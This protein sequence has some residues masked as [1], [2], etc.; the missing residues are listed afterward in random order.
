MS[1]TEGLTVEDW[2]RIAAAKDEALE[3]IGRERNTWAR[4]MADLRDERDA[5]RADRD[6][7]LDA[8]AEVENERTRLEVALEDAERDVRGRVAGEIR[9]EGQRRYTHGDLTASRVILAVL[10]DM[11]DVVASGGAS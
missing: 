4:Q 11:A 8:K 2:Q 1:A 10:D 3:A 6:V 9:V 5:A 7:A